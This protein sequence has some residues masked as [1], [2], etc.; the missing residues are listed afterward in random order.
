M[1]KTLSKLFTALCMCGI[2]LC[3]CGLALTTLTACDDD[4]K[5]SVTKTDDLAFLIERVSPEVT[6]SGDELVY[7]V[8]LGENTQ[9][10]NRPVDT[11][12][13]ALNEFYKLLKDG[14]SHKGLT[15]MVDG[16]IVCQLTSADDT[17]QGTIT[18]SV[19]EEVFDCCG[20]VTFSPEVTAATGLSQIR[21]ILSYMWPP[22]DAGF[23]TDILEKLKG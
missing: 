7:G 16:S 21:F 13:D 23:V 20:I 19:P 8:Y 14:S 17:P 2:T 11:K 10:L 12:D 9:V 15:V 22:G 18:F 4:D 6:S 5:P 3:L 1:K